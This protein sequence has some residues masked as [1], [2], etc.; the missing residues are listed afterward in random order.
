[1]ISHDF[2]GFGIFWRDFLRESLV[3]HRSVPAWNP[4]ICC[5]VPFVEAI[6]GGIYYPLSLIDYCG[7]IFRAVGYNL[8]LHFFLAGMFM[9]SAARQLGLSKLPAAVAGL[10]YMLS[11]CLISW[12]APGHEG[13]IYVTAWFPLLVLFV[14]RTL[15]RGRL[16]D[17]AMAGLVYGIIILTP[18][19]Q[20]AY[21]ASCAVGLYAVYVI[22]RNYLGTREAKPVLKAL[23]LFAGGI[24][25]GLAIGSVQLVP[26]A[27]YL[28]T[29][30]PRAEA[31]KGYE[32]AAQYSLRE[33]EALS[34]IVP[35]FAGAN[36]KSGETR[37]WGKN[38]MKDNSE[39][40]GTIPF[41]LAILAFLLPGYRDKRFWGALGLLVFLYALGPTTPVFGWL[42][43]IIP[44]TDSLAGPATS[45]FIFMFCL[46]VLS[47]VAVQNLKDRPDGH[48]RRF[49]AV[50]SLLWTGPLILGLIALLFTLYDRQ[51]LSAYCR[52]FDPA[53][54]PSDNGLCPKWSA[55][56]ANLPDLKLGLW[57]AAAAL[58]VAAA[59]VHTSLRI[60][61]AKIVLYCLPVLIAGMGVYFNQR[62]VVVFN[63]ERRFGNHPVV[64]VVRE[65]GGWN[66][67]VAYGLHDAA[68]QFGWYRIPS[69]IGVHGKE[70]R[71]FFDLVGG[72]HRG[73]MFNSRL[74]N[75]TGT[76]FIVS[77]NDKNLPESAMD[78]LPADTIARLQQFTV[79]ENPNRF[80][81]AY[82]A[83]SYRVFE[84]RDQICSGV[85]NDS[86]DL[87]HTVYLE[88]EPSL[89]LAGEIDSASTAEISRY[90]TD[91]VIVLTNSAV[92]A[93]LVLTD[94]WFPAWCA[95]VDSTPAKI[96]RAYGAFRAVEVPAGNH[97]VVFSYHSTAKQLGWWLTLSGLSLV[98]GI[99]AVRAVR[100]LW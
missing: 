52:V 21:Y 76:R 48:N 36:L 63:P 78:P 64:D 43:K 95:A 61:R 69:T 60:G 82:L 91:S 34:Q 67:T 59:A 15:R 41:F 94:T 100:D 81:H 96:H 16:F 49:R 83:T 17:A 28:T 90:G 51:M 93:L 68:F 33:E 54:L 98:F 22:I 31:N 46:A 42:I 97:R 65:Y 71:W 6:H 4:W 72:Y 30:S 73:N 56:L 10:I 38:S 87:R 66:R 88:E 79:L 39:S 7:S 47:G 1:M 85:L 13:K 3:Q 77:L 24:I 2:V 50:R 44:Y 45:M 74:L 89:S 27:S 37:Y 12:V 8:I 29:D 35:E 5:G 53:L 11:P 62:F 18:H 99:F 55:A 57:L 25:L 80:S 84:G 14:D 20:L 23:G 58:T 32:F 9:Y 75:L 86:D 70:P 19:L 26:S 92:N 40:P